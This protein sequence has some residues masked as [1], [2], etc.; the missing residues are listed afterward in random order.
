MANEK[1]DYYSVNSD[2]SGSRTM[3]A[4]S[5]E[6]VEF[7]SNSA[8]RIWCNNQTS[9]FAPHWH[10]A[11]EIIMPAENWYD[12]VVCDVSY[13]IIPGEILIIPPCDLHSLKAPESG[14]RFIYIIDITSIAK[15]HGFAGIQAL[16]TSPL[17]ITKSSYPHIYNDVCSLL[18]QIRNEYF[19]KND[20]AELTI[21]SLLLNMF[22]KLGVNHLNSVS[23][24]PNTRLYKQKEY[25]NKFNDVLEYIDTHYMENFTLDDVASAVGFSKYHFSRLFKQYTGCSF[26]TYI[27]RCRIKVAEELLTQPNLSITEIAMQS[28]FPSISTFNRVFRQQKNCSPSEYREKNH[29]YLRRAT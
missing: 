12:A 15:L 19:D 16:L 23:L 5:Q 29:R 3:L 1:T 7:R 13:H 20:F 24:F 2:F 4:G 9:D 14:T 10:T 6:V 27:C 28:G 8:V 21:F 26:C 11:L 25:I 22:V 17:H 18:V